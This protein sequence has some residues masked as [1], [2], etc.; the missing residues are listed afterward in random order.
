MGLTPARRAVVIL[1]AAAAILTVVL[2][3]HQDAKVLRIESVLA[4]EDADHAP[5]IAALTGAALTSG[6]RY[7]VLTNGVQIFPAMLEAIDAADQRISFETYIYEAG[8]MADRFTAAFERAAA[9]GVVCNMVLDAVGTAAIV[10]EHVNRLKDAGCTV[11]EF[12]RPQWHRLERINYR[13]HRKILVVDGRVGFTGGVS[14]GDKW[15]GDADGPDHWR[16]TQ[17]RM[18]GP[19]VRLLEAG[20]YENFIEATERVTPLLDVQLPPEGEEGTS[21]VVRSSSTGGA[22]DLKRLY[23]LAIASARRT[24]DVQSP[25]FIPDESSAWALEQAV[26]RGV[27]IRVLVEGDETD[28]V[29]VKYASRS[30]YDRLVQQGIEIYEYQPTLM[31]AKVIVV[32]GVWSMFGS[33]NFDNRSLEL[34]DELN[35]AVTSR[36]LAARFLQ[37][38]EH[39]LTRSR[40]LVL[41]D[42]RRRPLLKKVRE[43]F[44]SAFGEVF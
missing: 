16:D 36:D 2:L 19:V 6:N 34:N 20:F 3:L 8:Q 25:Y 10:R 1:A 32:D 5:Y 24:L 21:F 40:R 39:D 28:A 29:P 35:V 27:R 43:Q 14:V 7:D 31:H 12:N 17:I 9:R 30:W 15:M 37:D 4:A 22:N 18:Q 42:W 38:F 44:W 11:S 23:L 33:A 26:Q 41:E 13:T